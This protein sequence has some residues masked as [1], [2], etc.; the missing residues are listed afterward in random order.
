MELATG[1]C[2]HYLLNGGRKCSTVLTYGTLWFVSYSLLV[3]SSVSDRLR[4][5]I[6]SCVYQWCQPFFLF[7]YLQM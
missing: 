1:F 6:L 7:A 2:K 3:G 5:Y 4:I